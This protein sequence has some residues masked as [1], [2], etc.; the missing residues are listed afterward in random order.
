MRRLEALRRIAFAVQ[1]DTRQLEFFVAAVR[2]QDGGDVEAYAFRR[3]PTSGKVG[4]D[5]RA[6]P[7]RRVETPA[8][9]RAPL[10]PK[11]AAR[12]ARQH[13]IRLRPVVPKGQTGVLTR[14]FAALPLGVTVVRAYSPVK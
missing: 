8:W 13:P 9:V 4:M 7:R 10:G 6:A 5:V 3:P 14:P 11:R 12:L 1:V 2:R